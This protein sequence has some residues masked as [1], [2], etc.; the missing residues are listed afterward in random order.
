MVGQVARGGAVVGVIG[1]GAAVGGAHY[2]K[3]SRE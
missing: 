3:K 1:V 2:G